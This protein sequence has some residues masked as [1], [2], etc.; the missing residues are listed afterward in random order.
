ME[1][2]PHWEWLKIQENAT[3]KHET[4]IVRPAYKVVVLEV[5]VDEKKDVRFKLDS[6]MEVKEVQGRD[7]T[8]VIIE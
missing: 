4:F 8:T 2:H 6:E 7:G 1:V 3:G 5:T